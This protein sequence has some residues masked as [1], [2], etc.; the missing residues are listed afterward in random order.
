MRLET[1]NLLCTMSICLV[2]MVIRR[3]QQIACVSSL[4]NTFSATGGNT[5]R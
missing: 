4:R 2:E 5:L 1:I 3:S